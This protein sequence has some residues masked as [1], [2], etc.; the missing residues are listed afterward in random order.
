MSK[1][2]LIYLEMRFSSADIFS[3]STEY[4]SVLRRLVQGLADSVKK[5]S[6]QGNRVS[7][8]VPIVTAAAAAAMYQLA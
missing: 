2:L 3:L 5:Y 4:E 6:S 7:P 8:V 1:T